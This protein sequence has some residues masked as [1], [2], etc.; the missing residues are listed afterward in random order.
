MKGII[1]AG[2]AGTRL[3]PITRAVSKQLLPVYDKPLIYYPVSTLML[4]GIREVLFVTTPRDQS[5][6]Q[7]LLGDGSSLGMAFH[8]AVQSSPDGVPQAF[9]IGREFIGCDRVALALGDNIFYGAGLARVLQNTSRFERGAVVFA[10]QVRDAERYGVVDFDPEGRVVG[11]AEKPENPRSSWAVPGLYFY[12]DRVADIAAALKP[13]AR[14]ELEI[15]DLNLEYLR[16]GELHVERIGRG[17]AWLDTSTPDSL[18]EA[19]SFIHAIQKRQGLMVAC[20]EEIAFR[21]GYIGLDALAALGGA[22]RP[23]DYA[24]YVLRV[25]AEESRRLGASGA[26]AT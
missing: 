13:S 16:L 23:G 9:T 21:M 3:H 6:Y 14:G 19:A 20:I 7:A 18:L 26:R 1:L 5:A 8:Y 4:A 11:L 2:G 12:D 25:V 17:V 22:M 10:Y 24:S 15:T